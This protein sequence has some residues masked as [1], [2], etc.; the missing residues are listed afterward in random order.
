MYYFPKRL[1]DFVEI[2]RLYWRFCSSLFSHLHVGT[3]RLKSVLN[4]WNCYIIICMYHTDLT[5]SS[6]CTISTDTK[7][8]NT[9][10]HWNLPRPCSWTSLLSKHCLADSDLGPVA[11]V[12]LL[13]TKWRLSRFLNVITRSW[14]RV[15]CR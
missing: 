1:H 3:R 11:D 15:S 10:L 5:Q 2:S 14:L 9:S 13:R 7:I 4:Y 8:K 6:H 12:S